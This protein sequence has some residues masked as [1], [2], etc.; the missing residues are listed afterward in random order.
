[1]DEMTW[2]LIEAAL[3]DYLPSRTSVAWEGPGRAGIGQRVPCGVVEQSGGTTVDLDKQVDVEVTVYA[4]DRAGC[5][6]LAAE[7]DRALLLG[8]NPG[9]ADGVF[10][11]EIAQVFGWSIDQDRSGDNYQVA[12]ATYTLTV[13]PEPVEGGE[14]NG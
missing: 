3:L 5:W 12:T 8:L 2:P 10:V 4:V 7:V 9:G 13:R 14:D 1:M 6:Q 11:D